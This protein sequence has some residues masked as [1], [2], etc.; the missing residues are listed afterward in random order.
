MNEPLDPIHCCKKCWP[1]WLSEWREH[2]EEEKTDGDWQKSKAEIKMAKKFGLVWVSGG[3]IGVLG[4]QYFASAHR[5]VKKSV[6]DRL[7]S[8][9]YWGWCMVCGSE[10]SGGYCSDP[11]CKESF[12]KKRV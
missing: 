8:L 6:Y 5:Y 1:I 3:G 9:P 11:K 2:F 10:R 7:K 12:E 4:T